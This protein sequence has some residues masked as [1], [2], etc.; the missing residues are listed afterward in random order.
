MTFLAS[1][2]KIALP[3]IVQNFLSSF[4]NMI[5][6]VMVGQLGSTDIAAV[7][8]GNQI[9]FVMN[10]VM[11][12]IVSG[13]SV[14]ISQYWGKR[15]LEGIHRT[16]GITITGSLVVSILFFCAAF[17]APEFCMKIYSKDALVISKGAEYLRYVAPGYIFFGAGFAFSMAARSTEH[18]FLPMIATGISVLLNAI[19]NYF[20]IF[21][22]NF[23]GKVI[24]E[25]MG[26]VG[27][28][29][30]TDIAR[31]VEFLIIIIVVY[32]KKFEIASTPSR[33]FK[34]Q[35]GFL[36][37]YIVIA[38]PVL[39]NESLWGTGAS[40]QQAI[41]GHA[42]TS[43]V[44]ASNITSTISNLVWTFFIGCGNAA[45][46]LIGKK[47]G[48]GEETEA[49]KLAN[50]LTKFMILAGA[51]LGLLLIPLSFLLKYLFKVE[52]EVL[53]MAKVMLYMAA[54]L[55]PLWSIN[56]IIVVG[57]CRSGGDTIVGMIIDIG[58]MWLISLPL[59]FIAVTVWKLPYWAVYL[60]V[61]SEHIFKSTMGLIRLKSGKWLHN[62]TIS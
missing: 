42:G 31:A 17:F 44:A 1:L 55:Y 59:G 28:A 54:L 50:Q 20:F 45:A 14:F 58:F 27:A 13:G 53:H 22:L 41:Y 25:P 38:L 33:Y 8:L 51:V 46:I 9:F 16:M 3:I 36:W 30:A 32:G 18:V 15:D 11:F 12:G 35:K 60:C 48:E 37:H 57:V 24:F 56:M 39:V 10:I 29:I 5:D 61:Q 49:R 52:P 2:F 21:G 23:Q 47:I 43:M 19:L 62:V 26:I 6:N 7:G 40:L 4:V 34:P